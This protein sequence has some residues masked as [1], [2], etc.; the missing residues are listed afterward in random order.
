MRFKDYVTI[1]A[2]VLFI[3]LLLLSISCQ[4]DHVTDTYLLEA[5]NLIQ[6]APDSAYSLLIKIDTT[7]DFNRAQRAEWNL[8]FTQAMDKAYMEHTT[9]SL[10]REATTYY[11]Q[12]K[13][14]NRLMLSYYTMGRVYQ[15][16]GDSPRAQ[17]YYFKALDVGKNVNDL[18]LLARIENMLGSLYTFQG[19]YEAALPHLKIATHYLEILQDSLALSYNLRNIARAYIQMDSL[20]RALE[21]YQKATLYANEASAPSIFNE[22]GSTYTDNKDFE[23][24]YH[25]LW[26]SITSSQG[27]QDL[28]FSYLSIGDYFVAINNRDSAIYYLNQSVQ[29]PRISTQ[30]ASYY[31]LAELAYQSNLCEEYATHNR[32]YEE[33]RNIILKQKHDETI[34]RMQQLYDYT[35]VRDEAEMY[36]LRHTI[37]KKNNLLLALS[38]LLLLTLSILFFFRLKSQKSTWNKELEQLLKKLHAKEKKAKSNSI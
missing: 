27:L 38:S 31:H 33:L 14:L 2:S 34:Q 4:K 6:I 7:A 22:L 28:Y 29:S 16:L 21:F 3:A 25:Y 1:L 30:A 18:P 20:D 32:K 9:D 10:I 17:E 8:L 15:E 26:K 5:E 37:A 24:A 12:Q 19:S 35:L 11:E 13:N 23:Q 36:Q